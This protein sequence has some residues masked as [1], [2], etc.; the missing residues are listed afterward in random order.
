LTVKRYSGGFAE[1]SGQK[2]DV[3]GQRTEDRKQRTEN[4]RQKTE[5]RKQ[6]AEEKVQ[7]EWGRG[8]K[9]LFRIFVKRRAALDSAAIDMRPRRAS[10]MGSSRM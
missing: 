5:D 8:Q 2:A 10:D 9:P 6:I 3:R 1:F 4:G 7:K